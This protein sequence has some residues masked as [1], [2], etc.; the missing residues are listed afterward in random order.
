MLTADDVF[1]SLLIISVNAELCVE[2]CKVNM[3]NILEILQINTIK[4]IN[5]YCT[6]DTHEFIRSLVNDI[7][8]D[9]CKTLVNKII[10]IP[11]KDIDSKMEQL[12]QTIP[13]NILNNHKKFYTWKNTVNGYD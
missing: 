4:W 3:D 1:S 6:D 9:L 13:D 8:Y 5:L 11:E 10:F 12:I 2:D 7:T